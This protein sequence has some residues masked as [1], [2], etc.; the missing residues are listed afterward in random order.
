MTVTQ[1]CVIICA[2]VGNAIFPT[3]R[4]NV[5]PALNLV[6]HQSEIFIAVNHSQHSGQ[7]IQVL[8]SPNKFTVFRGKN[9]FLDQCLFC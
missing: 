9:V 1:N 3:P 8:Y 4:H 6:D 7:V 2:H 5:R